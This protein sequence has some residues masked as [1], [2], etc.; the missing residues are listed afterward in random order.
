MIKNIIARWS[1]AF[2]TALMICVTAAQAGTPQSAA[3]YGDQ[4]VGGDWP[5]YGRTF[6]H[7]HYSPLRQIDARNVGRL[8]LAWS[9]NLE[10]L[11]NTAT[12]PIEIGG[13]L[14]FATG[15]SVVH[16]V[17]AASGRLLWRYDP[18]AGAKAGIN[19]RNGWG[20]RG[21]A[22]WNGK[23]YTGTVDG[24]LIAIDAR[25]G[26]LVW[27]VQTFEPGRAYTVS[28]A[29][30]ACDGEIVIGFGGTVGYSRGY[31]TAYDAE[32]GKRLWRFYTVPGNPAKG[33]EN[34]AMEMAA[35]TWRGKWWQ[36][37]GG[38]GD[39]WNT[40]AY[41]AETDT[42][43]IG[44]GNGYAANRQV[45]SENWGDNLFISSIIA[46]DRRTGALKWYYQTTPGDTWDFDAVE[47]IEFT[48]LT[49]GGKTRK[50][51]MQAPKNG[52]FYVIDRTTGKLI[53]ARPYAKVNWASGVDLKTGRPIVNTA[54]RFLN[55][56]VAKLWPTG[57]GAHNWMPMAYSPQTG[58]AY[59]PKIENGV[60]YTDR[61]IDLKSWRPP[62]NDT[63]DF[64]INFDLIPGVAPS[65]ALV[66]WS[67][68]TQR[69]VWSVPFPTYANGGILAT[70]GD[71]VFEGSVDGTF[72]AYDA[73]TGKVLWS[74]DA[75]APILGTPISYTVNGTQYVTVLTGLGMGLAGELG[76]YPYAWT[77]KYRLDPRSQAR[78]VL[79]F[80][81]NGSARL[82]ITPYEPQPAVQDPDFHLNQVASVAGENVYDPNCAQC[83][84]AGAIADIQAPDLRRSAVIL[85]AQAFRIVVHDGAR[86]ANGMP[87]F[88]ELSDQ[89]LADLRQFLRTQAATLR[90][91]EA[92][93]RNDHS[94]YLN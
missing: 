71:L 11:R 63:S 27:S 66:A 75:Q 80:A 90:Q 93:T 60:T 34:H 77:G 46:L 37:G 85:S 58:L 13:V 7:Q 92:R 50:V 2:A 19:L 9:R 16:A 73:R 18:H 14:Y 53:S 79:T 48:D 57:Y 6:G 8:E 56:T 36:R 55:G 5:G 24:R 20:V 72:K 54:A 21:I 52:F 67:P 87:V 78:R 43:F 88:Q 12:E 68:V 26:R 44:T 94:Y 62:T 1:A 15:L 28:G 64:A 10:P 33:F 76:A 23:V 89:Q 82:P 70:A 61:G 32:S 91:T 49:I 65:G 51:L 59:I 39:V 40:M 84:G 22:W 29:P 81:L 31:V 69:A 86:K 47:D 35:K 17:N 4:S 42:V 41:D 74:F 45:R 3:L 38:G 30:L 83:H 25:T